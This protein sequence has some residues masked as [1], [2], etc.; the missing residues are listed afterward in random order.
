M[1]NATKMNPLIKG[2][3]DKF[4]KDYELLNMDEADAFELFIAAH[5][6]RGDILDQVELTDLLLDKNV[7]GIDLAQLEVNGAIVSS[8]VEVD[9]ICEKANSLD[10][11]I[12]LVQVK[13]PPK[14]DTAEI[15]SFGSIAEKILLNSV[16]ADY[17]KLA[18]ISDTFHYIFEK[19]AP[20]LKGMPK[21]SLNYVTTASDR[22]VNDPV[23]KERIEEVHANVS[24]ISFVGDV[25]FEVWGSSRVYEAYQRRTHANEAALTFEKVTNLPEMPGVNQALLGVV[26]VEELLKLIEEEGGSLNESVFYEN[27][28]GFKGSDN[29]VNRQI[30]ATLKSDS[31]ALLPVLNN[32]ITVV[33]RSYAPQPGD[34]YSLSG[35]QVVN[36]CQTSHCIHMAKDDLGDSLKSVYV[37]IKIVVTEDE[38]IATEIIRA[39]NSQT[40][41]SDADLIALTNFQK[42]LE[43]YYNVDAFNIGLR[44]ERRSGQFFFK[45]VTRTRIVTISEQIRA[46][47]TIFLDQPHVA[48]RY[49]KTL[50]DE[51]G[52]VIFDDSHFLAPYVA[53]AYASY[54][55]ET[56]FRTSLEPEFKQIRYHILMAYKYIVLGGNSAELNKNSVEGHSKK[57]IDSLKGSDYVANFRAAAKEV[58][59]IAGGV[60]PHR[61]RLKR[62]QFT[63]E[64]KT[65]FATQGRV[66]E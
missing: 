49:P 13:R 1:G 11:S 35:Y 62:Q 41:V 37:P 59:R 63:Q 26:S 7:I 21:V 23:V 9:E 36:G 52:T 33:A 44:Y 58:I 14:I 4:R 17:P 48:S 5:I 64:M 2:L 57:L 61:D 45:Q 46:V 40:A 25:I 8:A 12:T 51:V 28:R 60:V 32:G 65:F 42:R 18:E 10:V 53:S 66:Q 3:F 39:T 31:R 55:L 24:D 34:K 27:V 16:S 54:R 56:A 19:Y 6:L 43:E 50:Y 30:H 29:E 20:R 15:L 38:G 47:A 22:S